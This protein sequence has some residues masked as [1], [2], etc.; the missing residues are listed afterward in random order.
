MYYTSLSLR[1]SV[2]FSEKKGDW[3]R[4]RRQRSTIKTCWLPWQLTALFLPFL[5]HPSE[6][7]QRSYL[8]RP[9]LSISSAWGQHIH[10]QNTFQR[11]N[12]RWTEICEIG[13]I[14]PPLPTASYKQL[15]GTTPQQRV[16][17]EDGPE[18]LNSWHLHLLVWSL[19]ERALDQFF[20]EGSMWGQGSLERYHHLS[21]G[22]PPQPEVPKSSAPVPLTSGPRG[23]LGRQGSTQDN[24]GGSGMR[25]PTA[26]SLF[27]IGAGWEKSQGRILDWCSRVCS[28][29]VSTAQPYYWFLSL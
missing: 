19:P 17:R 8:W 1:Q 9:W 21:A 22:C 6:W 24:E 10:T 27:Q 11:A 18:R 28:L 12:Q 5:Q 4:L 26:P 15:S 16:R 23:A 29:R 13:T 14:C 2:F 7:N 25:Q 3:F 20:P